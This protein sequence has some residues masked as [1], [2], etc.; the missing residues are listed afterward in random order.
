MSRRRAALVV[1]AVVALG[2][3]VAV[4]RWERSHNARVQND[5]MAAIYRTA[6]EQGLVSPL[7]D[8]WRITP[9]FDCLLYHPQG[10]P[11]EI[12]AYEICFDGQGRLVQAIDRTGARPVFP[13]LLSEPSLATMQ[14]PVARVAR[15]F[16]ALRAYKNSWL[17]GYS[18]DPNAIPLGHF[19]VGAWP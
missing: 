12:A 1:A 4:G 6:T 10:K 8:L 13:N 3:S 5:R 17:D 9:T 15:A 18:P 19:D 16:I 11:A 14:V 7:L 2:A